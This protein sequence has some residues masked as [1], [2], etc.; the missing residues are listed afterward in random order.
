[1]S[2]YFLCRQCNGLAYRTQHEPADGRL[3]VKAERRWCRAGCTWGAEGEK[4]KG[5]HWRTF[6]R[7]SEAAEQAWAGSF[8]T[9][10]ITR[11][12]ERAGG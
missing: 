5:M 4:P 12:L 10:R 6:N 11:F 7:L 1:M 9:A 3:L 8:N 2:R